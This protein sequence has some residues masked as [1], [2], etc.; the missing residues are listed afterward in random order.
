MLAPLHAQLAEAQATMK[1]LVI[2]YFKG[3]G[4]DIV[5]K[6]FD[7]GTMQVTAKG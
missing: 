3:K 2:G 6:N 1:G 4:I 5:G 7:E